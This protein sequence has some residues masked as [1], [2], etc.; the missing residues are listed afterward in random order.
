[1]VLRGLRGSD[2]IGIAGARQIPDILHSVE[3]GELLVE[4]TRINLVYARN[5]V[6][7]KRAR[8]CVKL[9][10]EIPEE[11]SLARTRSTGFDDLIP[12]SRFAF[13]FVIQ[14]LSFAR[15]GSQQQNQ[16]AQYASAI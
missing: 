12:C 15:A 1:L 13:A 2:S 11:E 8:I 16:R 5:A 9:I 7:E 6:E 14:E 3:R 4:R 10:T